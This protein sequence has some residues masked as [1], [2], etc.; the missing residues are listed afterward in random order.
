MKLEEAMRH[1]IKRLEA[2]INIIDALLEKLETKI[3]YLRNE[4][5]K[6]VYDLKALTAS[7]D[8]NYVDKESQEILDRIIK[9]QQIKR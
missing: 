6:K 1:E 2:E 4:R 8:E 7:F 5:S 9:G 3:Q